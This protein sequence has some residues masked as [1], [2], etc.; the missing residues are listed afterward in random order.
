MLL[1]HG[2]NLDGRTFLNVHSLSSDFRLNAYDLPVQCDRYHGKFDDFMKLVNEFI[3]LADAPGYQCGAVGARFNRHHR[4]DAPAAESESRCGRLDARKI[5]WPMLLLS[6][7]KDKVFTPSQ[8]GA[9][10]RY[11]PEIEYEVTEGG[12][13]NMSYSRGP[14]IGKHIR[15]F[16]QRHGEPKE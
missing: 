9:I 12:T 11:I 15:S 2:L 8:V 7:D 4:H 3:D 1:F 13:H 5:T 16:C 10:R 6:G 14:G